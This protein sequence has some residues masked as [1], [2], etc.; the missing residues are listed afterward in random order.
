MLI[1]SGVGYINKCLDKLGTKE[2]QCIK[3]KKT[4]AN[5]CLSL[6]VCERKSVYVCVS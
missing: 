4:R 6:S 5:S 3:I 2:L 1:G